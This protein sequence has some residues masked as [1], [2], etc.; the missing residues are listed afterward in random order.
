[1]PREESAMVFDG[2]E[3]LGIVEGEGSD[4]KMESN[5]KRLNAFLLVGNLLDPVTTNL[6]FDDLVVIPSKMVQPR[7]SVHAY[8]DK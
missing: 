2:L 4:H 1:M 3:W 8:S 5:Q 7:Q 6:F